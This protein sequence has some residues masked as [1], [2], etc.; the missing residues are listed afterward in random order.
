MSSK[1]KLFDT[2][3]HNLHTISKDISGMRHH[4]VFVQYAHMCAAVKRQLYYSTKYT[5]KG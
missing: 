4:K 1:K 5:R 3:E 2:S